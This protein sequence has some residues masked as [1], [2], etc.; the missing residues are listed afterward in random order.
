MQSAFIFSC[1]LTLPNCGLSDMY[2]ASGTRRCV[3]FIKPAI[4]IRCKSQSL[5][6]PAYDHVGADFEGLVTLV[7][8]EWSFDGEL[9]FY[10]LE[11]TY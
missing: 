11:Y 1:Y 5:V 6:Q 8:R 7:N 4:R 10:T 9:H 3:S 2:E